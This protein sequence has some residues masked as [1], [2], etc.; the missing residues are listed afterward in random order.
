MWYRLSTY[1]AFDGLG[2]EMSSEQWLIQVPISL[3]TYFTIFQSFDDQPVDC[4]TRGKMRE[5]FQ[6]HIDGEIIRQNLSGG[7]VIVDSTNN[8][9][10]IVDSEN[11]VADL[12]FRPYVSMWMLSVRM[13]RF[14][15]IKDCAPQKNV[16]GVQGG[17][18]APPGP[19]PEPPT[20]GSGVI[21][22]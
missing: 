3:A 15:P 11:L 1:G 20:T 8:S 6:R 2:Q 18:Q 14:N 5:S 16:K 21:K 17:Y 4:I 13:A 7:D 19:K 10:A 9:P 22:V 12:H